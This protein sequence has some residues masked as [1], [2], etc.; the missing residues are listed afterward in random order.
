M[1]SEW[2]LL[3][4]VVGILVS[5]FLI[6][7]IKPEKEGKK[8]SDRSKLEF[9]IVMVGTEYQVNIRAPG[10][11]ALLAVSDTLGNRSAK[12]WNRSCDCRVLHTAVLHAAGAHGV[13]P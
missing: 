13:A 4:L 8:M 1:N 5:W 2:L 9:E 6:A 10:N 12:R 11:R 3:L 7:R